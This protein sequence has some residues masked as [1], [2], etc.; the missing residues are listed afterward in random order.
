MVRLV[1]VVAFLLLLPA[2]ASGQGPTEASF[3][4]GDPVLE[5]TLH[6]DRGAVNVTLPW[7]YNDPSGTPAMGAGTLV[8]DP[9][10]CAGDDGGLVVRG[11]RS[12]ALPAYGPGSTTVT[13][14]SAFTVSATQAAPGEVPL[15]CTFAGE[16]MPSGPSATAG[17]R[18][19]AVEITL[20]VAYLG[21]ITVESLN[22]VILEG[23]PGGR[24]E[25]A[26]RIGNFGNARSTVTAEVVG[27]VPRGW[28]VQVPPPTDVERG[29]E[30]TV[31]VQ[32]TAPGGI[33]WVNGASGFS[34]RLT[35]SS[36]GTGAAGNSVEPSVVARVR[37]CGADYCLLMP[38]LVAAAIVLLVTVVRRKVRQEGSRSG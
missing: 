7:T 19:D 13:G 1:A 2:A 34:I 15:R 29:G 32:V 24:L 26:F 36:A 23:A 4:I 5:G 8:W 22:E 37:G 12:Q 35:S 28:A 27:E 6:P 14:T 17:N 38:G 11:V 16:V 10:A 3:T 30:A 20:V 21:L 33:G 31:A 25:Y 18:R 9:P